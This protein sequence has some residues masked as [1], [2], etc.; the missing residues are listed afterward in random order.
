MEK[1]KPITI[2]GC[3]PGDSGYL[4][5]AAMTAV[6]KADCLIGSKRLLA[7]FAEN[8]VKRIAVGADVEKALDEIAAQYETNRVA[9]LV[10]GD[11]GISS[12]AKPLIKH[13]GIKNC[14]VIPGI[15]SVQLAFARLGLD[16]LDAK[17]VSA[18]GHDPDTAM[19]SYAQY[20]KI[21]VLGG[22]DE[23]IAWAHRLA[24]NLFDRTIFVCEN[25]SLPDEKIAELTLEQL[26]SYKAPSMT[27]ILLIKSELIS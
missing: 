7:M 24:K 9:V 4:S 23:S 21:A 27:I 25:L 16:W 26:G 10:S 12:L 6:A 3:G 13:F 14:D 19:G 5:G 1:R 20:E 15:S 17:I 18:H 8:G 2:I 11:P 22:R